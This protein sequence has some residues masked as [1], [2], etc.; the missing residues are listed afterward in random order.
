VAASAEVIAALVFVDAL[1][2]AQVEIPKATPFKL[3]PDGFV[4]DVQVSPSVLVLIV[5]LA[6]KTNVEFAKAIFPLAV[7]VVATADHE[8]PP[9]VDLQA[10]GVKLLV[11][12]ITEPD[13]ATLA[14][15]P[16]LAV[17]TTVQVMAS[18]EVS[19]TPLAPTTIQRVPS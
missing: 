10:N 2:I 15:V 16:E 5:V 1:P 18:V 8:A 13:D 12:T 14:Q 17:V 11:A 7:S 9:F 6:A 19:D 3:S 4:L